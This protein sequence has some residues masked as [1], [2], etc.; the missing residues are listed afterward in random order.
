MSTDVDATPK[1][2]KRW[3]L[4]LAGGLVI[5]LAAV[6]GVFQLTSGSDEPADTSDTA[7]AADVPSELRGQLATRLVAVLEGMTPVRGP[8]AEPHG[9]GSGHAAG[10]TN[11]DGRLMPLT[12]WKR[13]CAARVF[14][15]EPA[16]AASVEQVTKAY[17]F[18]VC[19]YAEAGREFNLAVK[20]TG[21]MAVTL[22]ADPPTVEIVE[23][24]A[25]F[26]ARVDA[27]FPEPYRAEA[28]NE[29]LDPG[30]LDALKRRYEE[31]AKT[32]P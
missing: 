8:G 3:P 17:G 1:A 5:A 13:V 23:G 32:I 22:T 11:P 9:P 2:R 10:H 7:G 4:L 6:V 21:P 16:G 30:G 27:L 15:T 28:R 14:G 24:G 18:H 19:A 26:A 25:D 31:T 12:E 20:D 29:N